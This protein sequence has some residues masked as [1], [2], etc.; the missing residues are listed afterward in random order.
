MKG[1]LAYKDANGHVWNIIEDDLGAYKA[2]DAESVVITQSEFL[3][4]I[5][6]D[7]DELVMPEWTKEESAEPIQQAA[8]DVRA[9]PEET[10]NAG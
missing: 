10:P 1:Q 4:E 5:F 2:M 7:I 9:F 3:G 6:E 8:L